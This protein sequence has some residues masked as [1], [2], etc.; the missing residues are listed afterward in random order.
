MKRLLLLALLLAGCSE[1]QKPQPQPRD[2]AEPISVAPREKESLYA[3]LGGAPGIAKV[4]DD[5]VAIIVV[6]ERI[7]DKHRKHFREGDVA[8]L[9]RKLRDQVGEATGGP[10][11]YTGKDMKAAHLGLGL[12]SMDFDVLVEDLA[13]AMDQNG[14]KPA[15]RDELLA[16]LQTMRKDVIEK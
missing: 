9:K 10:E 13:K 5:F 7:D 4:V 3:R 11:K 15:D 8:G 16:M 12:T 14:V 1:G 6:D 2:L